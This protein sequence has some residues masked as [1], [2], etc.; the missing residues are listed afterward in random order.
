LPPE[1]VTALLESAGR[2]RRNGNIPGA[3]ALLRA[4]SAQAPDDQRIW[5]ALALVA[6]TRMEQRRALER[7][8]ALDPQNPLA[9]RGLSRIGEAAAPPVGDTIR[10]VR[11][12]PPQPH[13]NGHATLAAESAHA[14]PTLTPIMPTPE[15]RVRTL[16][17]PMYA[18]AG[19]SLLL[20]LLAAVLIRPELFLR[21]RPLD[22][23]APTASN[24]LLNAPTAAQPL[25]TLALRTAAPAAAATAQQPV[26]TPFT[27]PSPALVATPTAPLPSPIPPASPAPSPPA[28]ALGEV[29]KQGQWHAVLIRPSDAVLLDG[30][31]G[32][33][34]PRGRFLLVLLAIGNDGSTPASIPGDLFAVLDRAGT[35]YTPLPAMSTAY[36]DAYGRGVRGDLSLEDTIPPDGSNRSVPLIFDVPAGATDLSLVVKG[37]AKG[38]AILR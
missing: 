15:E 17:W 37:Q 26:A 29:V 5:L 19:A 34:Q 13:A 22:A 10:T 28:L 23:P 7:V 9:R 14:A 25:P 16:R 33:A 21:P 24:T 8:I 1:T 3:R 31:I 12:A 20:V 32:T 2:T 11:P 6:E 18:V 4:L 30:S 35:R 38:W 27:R 36:L